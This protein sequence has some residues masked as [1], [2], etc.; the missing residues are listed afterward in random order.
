MPSSHK[1]GQATYGL[2]KSP[3]SPWAWLSSTLGNSKPPSSDAPRN[4]SCPSR[5]PPEPPCAVACARTP[6]QGPRGRRWGSPS[7]S[8]PPPRLHPESPRAPPAPPCTG[9]PFLR[10]RGRATPRPSLQPP[11]ARAHHAG[12]GPRAAPA[13]RTDGPTDN[14]ARARAPPSASAQPPPTAPT[15]RS[16]DRPPAAQAPPQPEPS[17]ADPPAPA[18]PPPPPPALAAPASSASLRPVSSAQRR[19][20]LARSP[21]RPLAPHGGVCGGG[22][23]VTEAAEAAEAAPSGGHVTPPS[24]LIGRGRGRGPPLLGNGKERQSDRATGRERRAA[25]ANC[26]PGSAQG[27]HAE[28]GARSLHL[29]ADA[30]YVNC[31]PAPGPAHTHTHTQGDCCRRCCCCCST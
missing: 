4:P 7:A 16:P 6:L 13:P 2:P 18:P 31:V 23:V 12:E 9:V 27:A 8:W 21:A 22:S 11:A 17:R 19:R 26:A 30:R 29:R 15:A 14:A 24:A 25:C 3:R 1:E 20:S 28:G 5:A 10:P